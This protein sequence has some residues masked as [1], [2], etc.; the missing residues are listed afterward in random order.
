MNKPATVAEYISRQIDACGKS[1]AQIAREVGYERPNLIS[2][3]KSGQA[4]LPVQKVPAFARALGVDPAFL[5]RL[6][7]SEYMPAMLE[8]IGEIEGATPVTRNERGILEAI[9]KLSKNA[10]PKLQSPAQH[11]ALK[12]F[13]ES[14]IG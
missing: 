2:M 8:V 12:A 7:V 14:M 1:Q 6:V 10:D 4:K 11:Q 13:V 5:F 9:R 3:I